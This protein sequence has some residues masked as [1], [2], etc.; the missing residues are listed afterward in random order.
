MALCSFC[1]GSTRG[2]KLETAVLKYLKSSTLPPFSYT[3]KPV[4]DCDA[5]KELRFRP[6]VLWRFL[7]ADEGYVVLEI[8]EHSHR[9]SSVECEVGRL[10]SLKE[11]L[12]NKPVTVVRYNPGKDPD[13]LP[14]L[15]LLYGTLSEV[16]SNHNYGA[17][18]A[19]GGLSVLYINYSADRVELLNTEELCGITDTI[20]T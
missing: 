19:P 2:K 20:L 11:Q 14:S 8:D 13:K 9:Y 16:F 18:D 5:D 6:D 3:D 10:Y 4:R 15:P 17:R 7:S 12:G 1:R